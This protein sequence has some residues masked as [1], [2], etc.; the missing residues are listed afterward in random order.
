MKESVGYNDHYMTVL[1]SAITKFNGYGRHKVY[2]I[3][4]YKIP[5][6][7]NTMKENIYCCPLTTNNLNVGYLQGRKGVRN[8]GIDTI[9]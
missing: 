9:N 4:I 7:L 3:Y 6:I 5:K 2:D 8:Y 1:S